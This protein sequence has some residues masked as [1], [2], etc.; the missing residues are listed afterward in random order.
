MGLGFLIYSFACLLPHVIV[1]ER[2]EDQCMYF[3][4]FTIVGDIKNL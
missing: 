4:S 3:V 1:M 2:E